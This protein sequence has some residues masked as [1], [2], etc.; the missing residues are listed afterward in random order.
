MRRKKS[1]A[2]KPVKPEEFHSH[3][4]KLIENLTFPQCDFYGRVEEALAQR[5]VPE[6]IVSRVDWAEGGPLSPRREYLR[7]TRE[8]LEFDICAAP[9]GTGFFVSIW[10]REKP[11]RISAF[12]SLLVL[13]VLGLAIFLI[14][15]PRFGSSFVYFGGFGTFVDYTAIVMFTIVLLA[16]GFVCLLVCFG[17]RL[18]NV[19]IRIPIIG[20]IYERFVRRVTLYR[21]DQKCMYQAAVHSAVTQVIDEICKPQGIAPLSELDRRP[22]SRDLLPLQGGN[23]HRRQ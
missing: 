6:L 14:A 16:L 19:L 13:I 7:L 10:L 4:P 12:K 22:V 1:R 20:T 5:L 23:G 3:W 9:F 2:E 21:I 18:D 8:R 15:Q 17:L 11:L